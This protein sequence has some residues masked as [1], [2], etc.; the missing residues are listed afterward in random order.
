M[1]LKTFAS[2][3]A[4]C[5]LGAVAARADDQPPPLFP[6][7]YGL[8][9][10]GHAE[11]GSSFNTDSPDNNVNF[12]QLFTDRANSVRLNQAMLSLERDLDPKNAGLQW[13]FKLQG[14]YGTDARITHYF[15]EFDR[16]T[17]SPYQWD[18]TE[19]DLQAHLPLLGGGTDIKL[20]QYPTPLGEEVIDTTQNLLYSKSYI[21][22]YGLPL[23]HTGLLT[24]THV[25]G[26]L[27]V[28]L[29]LDTG[30]NDS[31]GDKGMANNFLPKGI[32]GFGLNNLMGGNLTILA[33][34]H[35][36]PEASRFSEGTSFVTDEPSGAISVVPGANNKMMQFYDIV[37]SYKI[38]DSWST[39]NE[40]NYV[41]SDFAEASAGGVAQYLT[42]TINDHWSITGRA[43][44][45]SDQSKVAGG[46]FVCDFTN[47]QGFVNFERGLAP[48][49][50][51]C[52]AD[53]PYNVTYGEITLGATYKPG[54]PWGQVNAMI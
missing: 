23:K 32:I 38:N 29:G 45:F 50:G 8:K 15:N 46:G 44:V 52:G 3:A 48:S 6:L 22:N 17:N 30:V 36:G 37:T 11:F 54:L 33:L 21:F 35:I 10:S 47:S 16:M 43:E 25:N 9:L 14:M 31:L 1:K 53:V 42:Y 19:A 5:V 2:V 39:V 40:L 20:G 4:V 13:G 26:T 51:Y 24:T 34:S 27:D 41:K 49:L 7:P 12:G 28:W 18:V